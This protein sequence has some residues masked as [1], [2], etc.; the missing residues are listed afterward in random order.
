[1]TAVGLLTV[2]EFVDFSEKEH[3][4]IKKRFIESRHYVEIDPNQQKD[5]NL[6][7]MKN[8][9]RLEDDQWQIFEYT[10]DYMTS[11]KNIPF[12]EIGNP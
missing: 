9:I 6:F 12:F 3:D 10:E 7:V 8:T 4:K 2:N 11:N 5:I 1:M